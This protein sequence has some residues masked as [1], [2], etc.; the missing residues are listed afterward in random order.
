[1]L[2]LEKVENITTVY[3]ET[4]L[5]SH[6]SPLKVTLLEYHRI[7]PNVRSLNLMGGVYNGIFLII[8]IIVF[9]RTQQRTYNAYHCTL[10][11]S[12]RSLIMQYVL[13]DGLGSR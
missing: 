3:K 11:P 12:H 7:L 9:V 4:I 13:R 2:L 1:M 6:C 8:I 10:F 5:A